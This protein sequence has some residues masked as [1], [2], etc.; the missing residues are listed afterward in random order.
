LLAN[1]LLFAFQRMRGIA[2]LLPGNKQWL[3]ISSIGFLMLETAHFLIKYLRKLE[4]WKVRLGS[5]FRPFIESCMDISFAQYTVSMC[6]SNY[7]PSDAVKDLLNREDQQVTCYPDLD[8]QRVDQK[9]GAGLVA[10]LLQSAVSMEDKNPVA[11]VTPPQSGAI[12]LPPAVEEEDKTLLQSAVPMEDKNP[13]AAV[14][15]PQSGPIPLP[16]AV[17]E[18][19]KTKLAAVPLPLA[20]KEGV[21]KPTQNN[22]KRTQKVHFEK[23]PSKK[24]KL[25]KDLTG[26]SM[27]SV[28]DV[29]VHP[30]P[31]EL[32]TRQAVVSFLK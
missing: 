29:K 26:Q 27:D 28:P 25:S 14:T 4:G 22:P 2:S 8:V 21:P 32:T 6:V 23:M 31:L 18:E 17:K 13:V 1:A 30:G 7:S 3:I 9:L 11:A 20:V 24:S 16:P 15:P 10:P 12:P 5:R 19:D